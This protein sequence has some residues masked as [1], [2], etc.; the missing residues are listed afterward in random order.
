MSFFESLL[1]HFQISPHP[2]A[3]SYYKLFLFKLLPTSFRKPQTRWREAFSFEKLDKIIHI[4]STVWSAG[5]LFS[6]FHLQITPDQILQPGSG[7]SFLLRL[8]LANIERFSNDCRKTKTVLWF[9]EASIQNTMYSTSV[10]TLARKKEK[11]LNCKLLIFLPLCRL[12][13]VLVIGS[14]KT[15]QFH[16]PYVPLKL[17]V[18]Y[19]W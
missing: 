13:C 2:S 14:A 17:F 16:A 4:P 1:Y 18:K 9:R 5:L 10:Y 11:K 3:V 8:V 7:A 15:L 6:H 19:L 12:R